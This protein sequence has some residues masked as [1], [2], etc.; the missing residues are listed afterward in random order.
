MAE[1]LKNPHRRPMVLG[2]G[3]FSEKKK[4]VI[5][6]MAGRGCCIGLDELDAF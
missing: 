3:L 5:E 2:S 6:F 4:C 1:E